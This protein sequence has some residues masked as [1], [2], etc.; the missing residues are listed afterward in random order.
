MKNIIAVILVFGAALMAGSKSTKFDSVMDSRRADQKE[1]SGPEVELSDME[2]FLGQQQALI[3][4]P[5]GKKYKGNVEKGRSLFGDSKMGNCYACHCGEASEIACGNIGPSLKDF[6]KN[7]ME[8][9]FVY[10]R[11]YNS[12]SILPCSVMPR[13]GVH[14]QL[15]PGEIADIVAYLLDKKSPLNR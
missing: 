1:C 13:F 7:E 11:I 4:L 10:K 3:V 8:P 9:E 12:W 6:G 15:A 5:P 14:G 2:R